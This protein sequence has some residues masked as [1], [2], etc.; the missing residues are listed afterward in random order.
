[1]STKAKKPARLIPESIEKYSK[2]LE[3]THAGKYTSRGE[4][5][6]QRQGSCQIGY[7]I[8]VSF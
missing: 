6:R 1:M 2:A 8:Q 5:K 3:C 4:S 7:P